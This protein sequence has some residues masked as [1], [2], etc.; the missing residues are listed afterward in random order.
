MLE[1]FDTPLARRRMHTDEVFR[2]VQM[3]VPTKYVLRKD[4]CAGQRITRDMPLDSEDL[5]ELANAELIGWN[6]AAWRLF[7]V[8][9]E[10]L[11]LVG[12]AVT[13]G[14]YCD[15]IAANGTVAQVVDAFQ[16]PWA[17]RGAA[18]FLTVRA[19]LREHGID[20]SGVA[21]STPLS[22]LTGV[23]TDRLLCELYLICPHFD[24]Y[25]V[26]KYHWWRLFLFFRHWYV[27]LKEIEIV[28]IRTFRDLCRAFVVAESAAGPEGSVASS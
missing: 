26:R 11:Y 2:I 22:V 6:S 25:R 27:G 13:I 19:I 18:V 15:C 9:R 20:V 23:Q 28:G 3:L 7:G 1:G 17:C 4:P 8:P 10:R 12:G 5:A 21:P 16:T 24:P 14:D